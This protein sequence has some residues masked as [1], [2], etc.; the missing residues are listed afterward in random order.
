MPA[1]VR[2]IDHPMK[3]KETVVTKEMVAPTRLPL[4]HLYLQLRIHTTRL[5]EWRRSSFP[6]NADSFVQTKPCISI[7]KWSNFVPCRIEETGP[8]LHPVS[9]MSHYL[10]KSTLLQLGISRRLMRDM[11]VTFSYSLHFSSHVGE[12]QSNM[13]ASMY[14]DWGGY[15][16]TIRPTTGLLIAFNITPVYCR[17]KRHALIA[18]SS[19][20]VE[21]V[22][23]S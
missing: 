11:G 10:D 7:N 17:R 21:C 18:I 20:E 23:L 19:G 4:P 22:A 13:W 8:F 3:Y 9:V 15:Q 12:R 14:A 2:V 1:F 5:Q 16:T 6:K